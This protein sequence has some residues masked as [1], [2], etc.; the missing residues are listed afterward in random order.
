M[1][2][3]YDNSDSDSIASHDF[4]DPNESVPSPA[5]NSAN[6]TSLGNFVGLNSQKGSRERLGKNVAFH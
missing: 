4:F 1:E 6:I 5:D 3:A 2:N